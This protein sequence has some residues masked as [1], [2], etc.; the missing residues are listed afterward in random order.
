MTKQT[1]EEISVLLKGIGFSTFVFV[2]LGG[3]IIANS[4]EMVIP[5]IVVIAVCWVISKLLIAYAEQLEEEKEFY[6]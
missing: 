3:I 5:S 1:A 2:G 6:E 4:V